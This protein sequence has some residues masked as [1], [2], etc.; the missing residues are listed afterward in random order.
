MTCVRFLFPVNNRQL[1]IFVFGQILQWTIQYLAEYWKTHIRYSPNF[2]T[3]CA[4]QYHEFCPC[5]VKC[6]HTVHLVMTTVCSLTKQWGA[7]STQTVTQTQSESVGRAI[8]ISQLQCFFAHHAFQWKLY[9]LQMLRSCD[10]EQKKNCTL[11]CMF[12]CR[13]PYWNYFRRITNIK[14]SFT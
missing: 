14:E 10:I 13:R 7:P 4:A 11:T 2:N 9:I 8:C 5:Q 3:S 6:S 1:F 12:M